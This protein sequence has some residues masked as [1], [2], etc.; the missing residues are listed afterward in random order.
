MNGLAENGI[1][2]I[3]ASLIDFVAPI[4]EPCSK[5]GVTPPGREDG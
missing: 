2:S 4:G 1:Q 5:D 3:D